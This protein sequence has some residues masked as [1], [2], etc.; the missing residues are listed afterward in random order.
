MDQPKCPLCFSMHVKIVSSYQRRDVMVIKCLAC[1]K[2]SEIDV[3]NMDVDLNE[4]PQA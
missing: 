2:E 1:G 3:E 4:P